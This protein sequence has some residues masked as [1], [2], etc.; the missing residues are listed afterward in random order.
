MSVTLPDGPFRDSARIDY[1]SYGNDL[2]S[3]FGGSTQRIMRLGDRFRLTIT[4]PTM[5][6]S[7]CGGQWDTLIS[8]AI[9]LGA[10]VKIPKQLLRK[11]T[12]LVTNPLIKGGGQS[13]ML[14]TVDG[15]P[16]GASLVMDQYFSMTVGGVNYLHRLT[17][18]KT[19]DGSGEAT[20]EIEPMLR[21]IPPDNT[22]LEFIAPKIE[23]LVSMDTSGVAANRWGHGTAPEITITENR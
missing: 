18:N 21:V 1:V 16:A 22:T 10:I 11:G 12:T 19:A 13:G 15:L 5:R 7:E 17:A 23:G 3:P 9:R 14:I 6:I 4:L 20:L 2:T 8:Q